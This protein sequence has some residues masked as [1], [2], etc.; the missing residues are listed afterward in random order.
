MRDNKKYGK[1]SAN[2]V[3]R[4]F[5]SWNKPKPGEKWEPEES[6]ENTV[7][8]KKTKKNSKKKSTKK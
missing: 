5:I 4:D 6:K 7:E 8:N 3:L 1:L 2:K